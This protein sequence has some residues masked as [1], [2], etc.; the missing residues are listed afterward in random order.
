MLNTMKNRFIFD[1][2]KKNDDKKTLLFILAL[3]LLALSCNKKK[4]TEKEYFSFYADGKYYNY[5]QKI[6]FGFL[7]KSQA[8]YAAFATGGIDLIMGASDFSKPTISGRVKFLLSDFSSQ[9]TIILDDKRNSVGVRDLLEYGDAYELREP[10][11]GKII[12][13]ERTSKRL[14]GT[15]EFDAFK[16]KVVSMNW[17]PTDTILKVTKGKFS[18]I[19]SP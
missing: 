19:P 15:F 8:L 13:T 1:K 9:D 3:P 16:M 17:E 7:G 10:L 6:E 12:F 18:I 2:A 11:T 4:Q 14:T 5:P